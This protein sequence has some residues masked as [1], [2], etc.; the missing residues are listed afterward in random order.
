MSDTFVDDGF[1]RNPR[2]I[3]FRC[4]T[5]YVHFAGEPVMV[6]SD[7]YPDG[8]IG[9]RGGYLAVPMYCENGNHHFLFVLQ[10]HKGNIFAGTKAAP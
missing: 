9:Y 10:F 6:E 7:D 2:V 1:S 5:D 4:Q 8:G 3:C